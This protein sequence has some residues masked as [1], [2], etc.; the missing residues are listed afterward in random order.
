MPCKEISGSKASP[1][2]WCKTPVHS[3]R[4]PQEQANNSLW[5]ASFRTFI[6]CLSA[7][8]RKLP[9]LWCRC[10]RCAAAASCQAANTWGAAAAAIRS[11]VV[12][13]IPRAPALEA[14][15]GTVEAAP[16]GSIS[17]I[18]LGL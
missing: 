6:P 11:T 12:F 3:L 2:C 7:R 17:R 1:R 10:C 16:G 5:D 18:H 15:E 13:T 14:A 8:G 9:Q 4:Q